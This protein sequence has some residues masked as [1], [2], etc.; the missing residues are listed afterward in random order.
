MW[1][2]L[3]ENEEGRMNLLTQLIPVSI[4]IGSHCIHQALVKLLAQLVLVMPEPVKAVLLRNSPS[5]THILLI[6][7]TSVKD[8]IRLYI[9]VANKRR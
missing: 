3:P 2:V 5:L 9:R 7:I 4:S 1:R 8:V 6:E